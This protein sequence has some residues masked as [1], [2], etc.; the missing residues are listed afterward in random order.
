MPT[1]GLE[2][3]I[4]KEVDFE[5]TVFTISPSG[6]LNIIKNVRN[7]HRYLCVKNFEILATANFKLIYT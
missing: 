4:Y 7:V 1:T 5:S 3:V 6:R 2:P